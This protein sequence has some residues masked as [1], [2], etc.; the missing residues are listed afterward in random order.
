L[1]YSLSC[2]SALCSTLSGSMN[3]ALMDCCSFMVC[4]LLRRSKSPLR[5]WQWCRW[6]QWLHQRWPR[7]HWS[8][9]SWESLH[10]LLRCHTHRY[11]EEIWKHRSQQISKG[12]LIGSVFCISLWIILCC[13]SSMARIQV[14]LVRQ[15]R[16]MR[17]PCMTTLW[18]HSFCTQL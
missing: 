3:M 16:R 6:W 11:Q 12:R 13:R 17:V 15:V 1:S 14:M 9:A 4:L 18:N 2:N 5:R 8:L 7:C 10:H